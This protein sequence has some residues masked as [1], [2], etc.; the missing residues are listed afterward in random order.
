MS[1]S[2]I[3]TLPDRI[4]IAQPAI[5]SL[6]ESLPKS[7]R[8]I[9]RPSFQNPESTAEDVTPLDKPA[10]DWSDCWSNVAPVK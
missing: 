3:S 7:V 1:T 4:K 8:P 5:D 2:N 9:A 6:I 10:G